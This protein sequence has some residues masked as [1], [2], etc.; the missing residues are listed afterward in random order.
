MRRQ[1]WGWG[2]LALLLLGAAAE[3]AVQSYLD[4]AYVRATQ[5]FYESLVRLQ[6]DLESNTTTIRGFDADVVAARAICDR[7]EADT[8]HYK[9]DSAARFRLCLLQ[10]S[11]VLS[12]ARVYE[13]IHHACSLN[14]LWDRTSEKE[15]RYLI[16]S[17]KSD[18]DCGR[19]EMDSGN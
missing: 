5:P 10:F 2:G 3:V 7:W 18:L 4:A 19:A 15:H 11:T 12:N 13:K 1:A 9:R 6:S 14:V 16:E 8:R 17:T